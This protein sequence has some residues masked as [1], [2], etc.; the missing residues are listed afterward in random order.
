MD[1]SKHYCGHDAVN[2]SVRHAALDTESRRIAWQLMQ[3]HS[4]D[5][6]SHVLRAGAPAQTGASRGAPG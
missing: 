5:L 2:M 1:F 6:T 4:R 3:K